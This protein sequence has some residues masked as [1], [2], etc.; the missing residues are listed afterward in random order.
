MHELYK[1]SKLDAYSTEYSQAV[2]HPST[3]SAQCCLTAVIG[4]ELV[5]STWYGRR[6][7][8]IEVCTWYFLINCVKELNDLL[9]L[10][11]IPFWEFRRET[12]C[13]YLNILHVNH[14][15]WTMVLKH[16]TAPTT[17]PDFQNSPEQSLQS[18][19][20]RS[21]QNPHSYLSNQLL[22]ILI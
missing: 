15:S 5:F 20:L 10:D 2:T 18:R 12:M 1:N 7:D 3:N 4:R 9:Y 21:V 14:L 22:V 16:P 6:H 13:V 17:S 11:I 8:I 19:L